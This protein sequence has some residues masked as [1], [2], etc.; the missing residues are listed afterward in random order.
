M[1]DRPDSPLRNF[2]QGTTQMKEV[3]V[4][5]YGKAFDVPDFAPGLSKTLPSPNYYDRFTPLSLNP[6]VLIVAFVNLGKMGFEVIHNSVK[7]HRAVSI[8]RDTKTRGESP[9]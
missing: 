9:R 7:L 2:E 4:T 1:S 5:G 8:R 6:L 3:E